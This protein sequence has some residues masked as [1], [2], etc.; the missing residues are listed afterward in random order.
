[1]QEG[2]KKVLMCDVQFFHTEACPQS[3]TF[4]LTPSI[5]SFPH[6]NSYKCAGHEQNISERHCADSYC[7]CAC[8]LQSQSGADLLQPCLVCMFL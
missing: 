8:I 5:E 3:C 2:K 6:T 4:S 7:M 1:M